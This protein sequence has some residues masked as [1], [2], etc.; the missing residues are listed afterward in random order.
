MNLQASAKGEDALYLFRRQR[1][2]EACRS[3]RSSILTI[4]RLKYPDIEAMDWRITTAATGPI[5]KYPSAYIP[6]FDERG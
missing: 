1:R 4:L 5:K 2:D 6:S 3:A